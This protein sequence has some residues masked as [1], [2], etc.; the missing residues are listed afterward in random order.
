MMLLTARDGFDAP[1]TSHR[2]TTILKLVP[3]SPG[4]VADMVQSLFASR[5]IPEY[6]SRII[7]S[8]TDGNPLFVEEVGRSLLSRDSFDD[9]DVSTDAVPDLAIPDSLR[10]LLMARLDKSGVAKRIAQIAAVIGRSM[11]GDVLT[12]VA[13]LSEDVLDPPL[14]ALGEAVHVSTRVIT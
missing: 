11:R 14:E 5:E 2:T 8:R 10:E 6:L 13:G 12:D 1:W 9:L 3:M 7:A 4:D